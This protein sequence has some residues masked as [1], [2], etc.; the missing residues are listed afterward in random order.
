VWLS[1]SNSAGIG[2]GAYRVS[3]PSSKTHLILVP[4]LLGWEDQ[5][6]AFDVV[7]YCV[8]LAVFIAVVFAAV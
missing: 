7:I 8:V 5:G 3:A 1:R 2:A 4:A 6:L